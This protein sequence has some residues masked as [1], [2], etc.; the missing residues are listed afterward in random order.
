[1]DLDMRLPHKCIYAILMRVCVYVW[2]AQTLHRHCAKCACM[3]RVCLRRWIYLSFA[4][5]MLALPCMMPTCVMC[6][7]AYVCCVDTL[8][9]KMCIDKIT[10]S[11]S[12]INY[13]LLLPSILRCHRFPHIKNANLRC[14]SSVLNVTK[15]SQ[16]QQNGERG[17]RDTEQVPR[18][19]LLISAQCVWAMCAGRCARQFFFCA[20]K[21][22]LASN[23]E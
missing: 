3:H 5:A 4:S 14:S 22:R 12:K 17:Q 9:T 16:L 23:S 2:S 21:K 20:H 11:I 15:F 13:W 18:A 7:T 8:C 1:M 19:P 10:F 6:L